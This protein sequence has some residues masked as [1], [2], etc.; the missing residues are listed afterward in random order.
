MALL[1]AVELGVFFILHDWA[2]M[3]GA[4]MFGF[5]S[6]FAFVMNLVLP[7]LLAN[8]GDRY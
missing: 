8:L 5:A 6:A 2:R 3:V 1:A 7:P 4:G